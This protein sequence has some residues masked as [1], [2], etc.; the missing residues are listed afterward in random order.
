MLFARERD[1]ARPYFLYQN[2]HFNI[3]FHMTGDK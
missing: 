1:L 2:D 3:V